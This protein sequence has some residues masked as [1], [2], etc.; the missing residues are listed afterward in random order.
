QPPEGE[1]DCEKADALTDAQY[2]PGAGEFL[3][4]L[5]GFLVDEV[6]EGRGDLRGE[7][8]QVQQGR[9]E[10]NLPQEDQGGRDG[11][12]PGIDLH[13]PIYSSARGE[14]IRF[15]PDEAI[16]LS[17]HAP[18]LPAAL[19]AGISPSSPGDAAAPQVLIRPGSTP[20]ALGI[21]PRPAT[22]A[23]T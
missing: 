5:V 17:D 16:L 8:L 3:R 18:Y 15:P 14:T 1:E 20:G 19:N 21:R 7:G 13:T 9:E 4:A 23:S 10:V 11:E 22:P 2:R 6:A 12:E